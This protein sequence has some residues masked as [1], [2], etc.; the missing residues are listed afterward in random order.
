MISRSQLPRDQTPNGALSY[1]LK[2]GF[3]QG[4]GLAVAAGIAHVGIAV[5]DNWLAS[6]A[7][8][9]ALVGTLLFAL[10]E[11][12]FRGFFEAHSSS[13]EWRIFKEA[14]SFGTA[15]AGCLAV[16]WLASLLVGE[17]RSFYCEPT[18]PWRVEIA[19]FGGFVSGL[20]LEM[21]RRRRLEGALG[22]A[23]YLALFW[24][25]PFYGFFKAPVFLAQAL[26]IECESRAVAAVIIATL[27]ML[28]SA[29]MGRLLATWLKKKSV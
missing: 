14:V 20:L 21:T 8:M 15:F 29:D 23:V 22:P 9:V 4:I 17:A 27:G 7:L 24:I 11:Q 1:A 28:V 16:C 13:A 6:G 10:T 25:G 12:A 2:A 3:C 18:V 19:V 5:S 26:L